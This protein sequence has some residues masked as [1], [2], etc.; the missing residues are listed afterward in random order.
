MKIDEFIKRSES[1][2][3]DT[4]SDLDYTNKDIVLALKLKYEDKKKKIKKDD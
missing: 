1:F 2:V 4:F 3:S